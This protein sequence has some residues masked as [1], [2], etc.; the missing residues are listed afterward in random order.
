[1][2]RRKSNIRLI[3][4]ACLH[5]M[6][7]AGLLGA[8]LLLSA[9]SCQDAAWD[10]HYGAT[11]GTVSALLMEE[12][13]NRSE[14]SDFAALLRQTGGDSILNYNQTF[15]V[16]APTNEAMEGLNAGSNAMAEVVKNHVARYL[17]GP[18]HLADTAYLRIKMLNG[19]YQELT[20]SGEN[21]FFAGI[22]VKDDPILATNGI[23][24]PLRTRAEYYDNI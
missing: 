5:T 19:K 11:D 3:S 8:I 16:F 17:Y 22:E 7:K 15:T 1:M 21:M 23:I 10:D 12:L 13:H 2:N 20:R 6:P 4:D 18:S 24:Y 14:F 9:V